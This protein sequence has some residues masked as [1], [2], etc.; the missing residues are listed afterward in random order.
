MRIITWNCNGAFRR[1]YEAISALDADIL[2]IQECE[3]PAY[4]TKDYADWAGNYV[5]KGKNNN[6]GIGIFSRN[7]DK[8]V[9][10]GWDDNNFQ[11]FLSISI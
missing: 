5:W 10:L 7:G 6:K 2:V 11:Q 8:I 4:S 3:D 9:E 1:K